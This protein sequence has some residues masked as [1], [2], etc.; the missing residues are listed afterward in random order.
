MF[1][2]RIRDSAKDLLAGLKGELNQEIYN[3]ALDQ[4]RNLELEEVVAD[5]L[6]QKN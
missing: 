4:G 1:E 3:T 2:G 6:D 5:L